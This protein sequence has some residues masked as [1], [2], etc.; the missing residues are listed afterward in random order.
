MKF[1]NPWDTYELLMTLSAREWER[2]CL[3]TF[4][5]IETHLKGIIQDTSSR[6]F[7]KF[8]TNGLQSAVRFVTKT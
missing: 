2:L 4:A 7:D 3:E 1:H 5:S 6:I 8:K